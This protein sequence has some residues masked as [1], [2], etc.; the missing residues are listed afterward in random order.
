CLYLQLLFQHA[1]RLSK[2]M[3]PQIFMQKKSKEYRL[4]LLPPFFLKFNGIFVAKLFSVSSLHKQ[5]F[6]FLW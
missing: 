4:N 1:D 2:E 3:V 5:T 6:L